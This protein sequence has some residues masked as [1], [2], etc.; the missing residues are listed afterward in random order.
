[1]GWIY[2]PYY[3]NY[4]GISAG[5]VDD[6]FAGLDCQWIY[7]THFKTNYYN[8]TLDLNPDNFLCEVKPKKY[9]N[10]SLKWIE[11]NFKTT[12]NNLTV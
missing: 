11:T 2:T 5:W 12:K 3:C 1:M 7:V 8:L 9:S 6:Y 10:E 4:Q